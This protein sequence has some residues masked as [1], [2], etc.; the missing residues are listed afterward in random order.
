MLS[1]VTYLTPRYW[2]TWLGLAFFWLI[3]WLPTRL[4]HVLGRALGRLAWRFNRKR[5]E[6]VLTNLGQCFPNWPQAQRAALGQRHFERMGESILDASVLWFGSRRRVEAMVDLQGWEHFEAAQQ[7]GKAV[8][9]HTAHWTGLEFCAAAVS[10]KKTG[11]GVFNPLKNPLV[12]QRVYRARTR[13]GSRLIARQEGFRPM[14]RA[15]KGGEFLYLI[16]DED[17]GEQQSVFT[18]FFAA[19]KA[20]LVMPVRLARL[21]N[22]VLLPM[23]VVY[24][25]ATHRYRTLILPPLEGFSGNDD[26][27]DAR[28]LS[29]CL[30][31]QIEQAPAQYMWTLKLFRTQPE[32]ENI[33]AR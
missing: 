28:I 14:I 6:V 23:S 1:Q 13:F 3:H 19:T 18:T 20:T 25:E 2:A 30:E 29:A 33:Y 21:A 9:F 5:R 31:Q 32:G 27:P 15:L 10:L 24:D 11:A 4:R 12:N 7:Q 17:H 22:A 8:I 26:E 16:S